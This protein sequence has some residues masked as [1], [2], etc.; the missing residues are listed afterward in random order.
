MKKTLYLVLQ[1]LRDA[2]YLFLPNL[3]YRARP[4]FGGGEGRKQ[5]NLKPQI[6][7]RR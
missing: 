3:G 7:A 6:L 4:C 5:S 2:C 1:S